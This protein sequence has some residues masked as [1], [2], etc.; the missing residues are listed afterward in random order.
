MYHKQRCQ[1]CG[2]GIGE[3]FYGKNADGSVNVDYCMLCV[4]GGEFTNPRLT[5][6]E[7]IQNTIVNMVNDLGFDQE[8]ATEMA[9]DFIPRLKRWRPAPL[10]LEQQEEAYAEQNSTPPG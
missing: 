8:K 7:V 3:G 4:R 5:M 2:I 9:K 6:E 10:T 1:S